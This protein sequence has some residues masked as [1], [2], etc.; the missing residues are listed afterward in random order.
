MIW[1]ILIW[2]ATI[3]IDLVTDHRLRLKKRPVNHA[4][5]ALL[6]LVGLVP[7]TI[8]IP[9]EAIGIVW[10]GYWVAFEGLN[11]LMNGQKWGYVGE[12]AWIDKMTRKYPVIKWLKYIGLAA[13]IV[14]VCVINNQ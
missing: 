4:R 6:R 1:G 5:G 14:I 12:T 9:F 13:S 10:F 11:N 3:M 2:I 7:A 8:L